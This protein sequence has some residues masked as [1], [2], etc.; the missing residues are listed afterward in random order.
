[1][2]RLR[3][4]FM[5]LLLFF[6]GCAGKDIGFTRHHVLYDEEFNP[7]FVVI[8]HPH[9][10][11]DYSGNKQKINSYNIYMKTSDISNSNINNIS[12]EIYCV[13]YYNHTE[14]LYRNLDGSF[15]M[16][17]SNK[18]V[19]DINIAGNGFKEIY[20]R[21]FYDLGAESN[22][23]LFSEPILMHTDDKIQITDYQNDWNEQ[24]FY[25]LISY[26]IKEDNYL[27]DMEIIFNNNKKRHLDLQTWLIVSYDGIM[28]FLGIYN[29]CG[30]DNKLV[31]CDLPVE[32]NYDINSM[33]IRAS[34]WEEGAQTVVL[35]RFEIE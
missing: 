11:L 12:C 13:N 7:Y 28:P 6:V 9:H 27:F 3:K 21:F 30:N 22:E 32:K 24:A 35:Y 23:F 20:G 10:I 15:A 31:Y 33:Y 8:G 16:P 25:L 29:Y 4:T 17:L 26:E 34:F 14:L 18:I 19:S 5:L 2:K 1:M